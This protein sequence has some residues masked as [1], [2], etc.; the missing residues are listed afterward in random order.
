MVE[1]ID[2]GK[3]INYDLVRENLSILKVESVEF[4][5]NGLEK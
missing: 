4:L 1:D 3:I 5:T 2:T